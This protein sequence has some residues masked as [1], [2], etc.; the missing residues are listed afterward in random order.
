MSR[1]RCATARLLAALVALGGTAAVLSV[2]GAAAAAEEDQM[3]VWEPTPD[4]GFVPGGAV[5]P[6]DIPLAAARGTGKVAAL[7]FDDGPNPGE[8]ERLLD[9]LAAHRVT[10]TFCVIGQ[11]I[12]APG[13]AAILR[14]MVAEGHTLCNH[15]TTYADMGSWTHDRVEADLKANL[16][17]IREALGDP[18]QPVPYFRAPNGSWGV[19]GEVAAALGMQPLGLGNVIFDWDGNDLSEATLT[20]NLRDAFQPGAVVLAHDGGGDRDNTVDAVATVLAEKVAEGWAFPLPVGGLLDPDLSLGATHVHAGATLPVRI[21]G[22]LP[23][24]TVELLLV[25]RTVRKRGDGT[26][27]GSVTA[28]SG[29]SG[30]ASLTVPTNTHAGRY[31]VVARS[32]AASSQVE[33]QVTGNRRDER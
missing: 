11:N 23:D 22:F 24:R 8:T 5:D 12:S 13:G 10:A 19:T 2:T 27:I 20:A 32:G 33:V 4:A 21:E 25:R 31:V 18:R 17:I 14:R 7:T 1:W 29:G 30:A 9:I 16:A 6:T 15:A 3:A 28:G 26:V